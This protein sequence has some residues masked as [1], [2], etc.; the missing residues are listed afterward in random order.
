MNILICVS[1]G[2]SSSVNKT[3]VPSKDERYFS[4]CNTD[5]CPF[6]VKIH[7]SVTSRFALTAVWLNQGAP[8][9][10]YCVHYISG[11]SLHL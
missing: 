4:C 3:I 2:Y 1:E 10:A 6:S 8:E 11:A 5:K 7:R 9:V